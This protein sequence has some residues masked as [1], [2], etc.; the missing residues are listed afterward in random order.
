MKRNILVLIIFFITLMAIFLLAFSIS[1]TK[2]INGTAINKTQ[3]PVILITV[4]SLMSLPL[5]KGIQEGK[6]PAFSFLINN[7][8]FHPEVISS[9]P[10][11]SVTIDSTLL[12]GTYADQHKIPGLIWFKEDENHIIS[13]GSGLREIWSLGVKNVALDSIVHLNEE[14]LSKSV[15]TIHEK[16]TN[17]NI[18]SASINGLLYRGNF[19]HQLNVPKLIS[20]M[21]LLPND[22][23]ISGPTLLSLGALSLYNPENDFHKLAWSRM[24]VNNQFTVNELKFLIEQNK[25]PAFTLAYLPDGDKDLHKNGPNDLRSIEKADQHLQELLNSY[26]TWEEAIEQ[27]IWIVHGDSAQSTVMKDKNNSLID[28]NDLLKDYTFWE[29]KNTNGEIAIAINE[30]MAYI[31]LNDEN[32]ELSEVVKILRKDQRI[33]IIAWKEGETNY[34]ISPQSNKELIFSPEGSYKDMYGQSWKLKGDHSILNLS[35]ESGGHIEYGD[36]PDGLAR[37][38]GALHSHEGRFIIV[39]AKPQYEFIE[40]HSHDH[41]GGGAHGS[42]HKID[43]LVPLIIT[44]TQEKPEYNR[45]VDF[46]EWII[47]LMK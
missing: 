2:D 18:Q 10:T 44:G 13:Y 36:Y 25:L 9:Y 47:K 6:A 42:L 37:L 12:T 15:Q 16:L 14:H 22:I 3:K 23:K 19:H 41:A 43:S 29:R 40:K 5:Q 31:N 24:G 7:G 4:D 34:V 32:V 33:G 45:L 30:R 20:T 26:S 17:D 46:K 35:I 38:Y 27:T 11:M 21:G 28:L 39:D 8:Q 1:P